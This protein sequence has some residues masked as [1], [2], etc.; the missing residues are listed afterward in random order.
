MNGLT[1]IRA[2]HQ[3]SRFEQGV[4]AAI[5][6]QNVLRLAKE[7]MCHRTAAKPKHKLTLA[8]VDHPA[9]ESIKDLVLLRM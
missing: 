1:V 3:I 5:D 8:E 4:Q 2:F 9:R 7:I 6:N